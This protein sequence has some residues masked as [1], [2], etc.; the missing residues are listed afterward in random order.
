MNQLVAFGTQ[1]GLVAGSAKEHGM[2]AGCLGVCSDAETARMLLDC[3]L[4]PGD[5]ILIK[6]SRNM[7]MEQFVD[8]LKQRVAAEQEQQPVRRVA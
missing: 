8:Y 3:W 2:D 4:E 7:Q 1:A 6:G 5:L